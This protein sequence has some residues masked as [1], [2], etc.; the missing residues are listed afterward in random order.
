MTE[1][2]SSCSTVWKK[3]QILLLPLFIIR[4]EAK[5]FYSTDQE[6]IIEAY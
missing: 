4:A 1:K 2:K 5:G 3:N 6:I